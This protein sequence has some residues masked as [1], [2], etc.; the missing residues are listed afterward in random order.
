MVTRLDLFKKEM[1]KPKEIYAREI[2]DF[3]RNYPT[4]GNM[5]IE[6]EPDIDVQQYIFYFENL[7]GTSKDELDKIYLEIANHMDEFSKSKGI[8]KFSKWAVIWL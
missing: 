1:E 6:E 7:N 5:T 2:K 4:L 3:S 8:E